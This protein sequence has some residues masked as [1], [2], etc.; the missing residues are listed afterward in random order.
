MFQKSRKEKKSEST[1]RWNTGI[2]KIIDSDKIRGE[3]PEEEGW[4]YSWLR[5]WPGIVGE[6]IDVPH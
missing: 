4:F 1:K 2:E 3:K 6:D 5:L